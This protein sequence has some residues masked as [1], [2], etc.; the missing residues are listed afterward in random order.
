MAAR[1]KNAARICYGTC[2]DTT[3]GVCTIAWNDNAISGI[4]LPL[5]NERA[6]IEHLQNRFEAKLSSAPNWVRMVMQQIA[7]H[8]QGDLQ[9]FARVRLDFG[10][11]RP[12]AKTVYVTARTVKPGQT[13]TYKALAVR[14]KHPKTARAV[15][16]ALGKNP[17]ALVVPCHRIV[18]GNGTLGGFSAYGGVG[19]KAKLLALEEHALGL[20]EPS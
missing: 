15:G 10:S 20:S 1:T 2:F 11:I 5:E 13:I 3:L 16:Q 17:F 18:A 6:A 19:T 8:L 7:L 4:A 12:F 14:A 9:N